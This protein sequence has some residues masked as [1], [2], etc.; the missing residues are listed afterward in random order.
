VSRLTQG[1]VRSLVALLAALTIAAIAA[2]RFSPDRPSSLLYDLIQ[3]FHG[4]G[5]ATISIAAY[6]W[7]RNRFAF[8]MQLL[9]AGSIAG[10]IAVISELAQVPGPRNAQVID[11]VVD[12]IGIAAGLGAMI[13]LDGQLRTRLL[14]RQKA[15]IIF[16]TAIAMT[17]TFL[18]S[19]WFAYSLFERQRAVPE[20]LTFEHSWENSILGLRDDSDSEVIER[21]QNWPVE[22]DSIARLS[23]AGKHGI[24]IRV[25]PYPDWRGFRSV[26]F[27]ASSTSETTHRVGVS[28]RDMQRKKGEP[29][30]RSYQVID[31]GK[32]PERFTFEFDS[33]TD[34][35]SVRAF[36]LEH[37]EAVVLSAA[38]PGSGVEILADDF[39]LHAN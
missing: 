38:E 18:P 7:A 22:G 31:V 23:E 13:L 14:R 34:N 32:E 17:I 36:D 39:R 15:A 9:I 4:P 21:P 25:F 33:L 28:I 3:S 1:H 2:H 5:F 16:V 8:P 6:W 26:S 29:E 12:G 37:V 24:L 10:G 27:V 11:L 20:L 35:D 30:F 19:V